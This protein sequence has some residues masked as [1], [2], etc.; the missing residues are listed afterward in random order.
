MLLVVKPGSIVTFSP[1]NAL[2]LLYLC[3]VIKSSVA[4]EDLYDRCEQ[5]A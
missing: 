2:E 3:R 1:Q 5:F 4:N